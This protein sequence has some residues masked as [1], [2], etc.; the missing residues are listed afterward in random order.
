MAFCG[1]HGYIFALLSRFVSCRGE[2]RAEAE[3]IRR[4]IAR[5]LK[6]AKQRE[7]AGATA[8]EVREASVEAMAPAVPSTDT[9]SV[10][11]QFADE[12]ASY[13]AKSKK[14]KEASPSNIKYSSIKI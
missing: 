7:K 10:V 4:D 6:A 12:V 11:D 3:A 8:T 5:T 2:L 14:N 1:V 13:R 9:P